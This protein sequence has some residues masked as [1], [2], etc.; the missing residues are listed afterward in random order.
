MHQLPIEWERPDVGR[1]ILVDRDIERGL[2]VFELG[3]SAVDDFSEFDGL[4]LE[5]QRT[6]EVEGNA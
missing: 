5:R 1:V 6:G 4:T 2:P 3:D